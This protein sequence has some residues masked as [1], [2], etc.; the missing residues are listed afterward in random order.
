MKKNTYTTN[1]LQFVIITFIL[2]KIIFVFDILGDFL[3]R[4]YNKINIKDKKRSNI[5]TYMRQRVEFIFRVGIALLMMYIFSPLN[6]H[7]IYITKDMFLLFYI[8]GIYLI[9]SADWNLFIKNK[10]IDDFIYLLN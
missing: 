10:I 5:F 9:L 7:T 4:T 2:I 6:D 1:V 3:F 8:L